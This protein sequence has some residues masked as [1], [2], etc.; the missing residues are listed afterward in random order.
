MYS[1]FTVVPGT[2]FNASNAGL[3]NSAFN[4]AIRHKRELTVAGFMDGH[5][6][7][8]RNTPQTGGLGLR[9]VFV[10]DKQYKLT[11]RW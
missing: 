8:L 10:I 7:A 3:P 6:E 5:V 1:G 4:H 2:D 11:T 9:Q